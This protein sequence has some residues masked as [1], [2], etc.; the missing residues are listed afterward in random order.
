MG[1]ESLLMVPSAS[2][3]TSVEQAIVALKKGAHLFT[4]NKSK[5]KPKFCLFRLSMDE[6]YMI[7]YSGQNEKQL[8]LSSIANII[9]GQSSTKQVMLDKENRT[10]LSLI[11]ANGKC[12][13]QLICKDKVETESWFIG[14]RAVISRNYGN[15]SVKK[16][17]RGTQSCINS[18]ASFMRRKQNLVHSEECKSRSSQVHSLCGSP[19]SSYSARRNSNDPIQRDDLELSRS[20]FKELHISKDVYIWGG[21]KSNAL[22]LPK[23]VESTTMLDVHN[24]FLGSENAM[25]LTTRWGEAYFCWGEGKT[26]KT[27]RPKIIESLVGVHVDLISS[28]EHQTCAL[29]LSGELYT[30][31]NNKYYNGSEDSNSWLP[32]RLSGSLNGVSIFSVAC[33]AWHSAIVSHSGELFTYG[34]GTFGVL[35]HGD[36]RNYP[37]PKQV[38]SVK[39]LR[40]KAVAC[41]PWHTAAIIENKLFTWGDSDKGKLGHSCNDKRKVVLVPTYVKQLFGHDFVQVSCGNTITVVLTS[42]GRVYTMGSGLKPGDN[43]IVE[44]HGRLTEEFVVEISSGSYHIAVLT[45]KGNVYTWGK[46]ENGQ[47][48]LGDTKDR[49]SPSLVDALRGKKVEKITCGSS[50]TAVVCSDMSLSGD[51]NL[52]CRGCG[53]AFGFTR[54][55]RRCYNCGRL[56]CGACS[57]KRSACA[58]SLAPK[59]N[60]AF[61]VCNGCFDY[62]QSSVSSSS[63]AVF[64]KLAAYKEL[65]RWGQVSCPRN[66]TKN[67]EGSISISAPRLGHDH[68]SS[69]AAASNV[70]KIVLLE[71]IMKLKARVDSLEKLCRTREEKIIENR[72]E[73]EKAWSVAEEE[74]A[75]SKEAKK[76]IQALTLKFRAMSEKSYGRSRELENK[77]DFALSQTK[78]HPVLDVT[79]LPNKVE[80]N[81]IVFSNK[82]R[83]L[84]NRNLRSDVGRAN[85]V[86]MGSE[87]SELE[88]VEEHQPGIYISF[89]ALPDG[90]TCLKRVRFSRK[91]FNDREAKRWWEEN[92]Q[93]VCRNYR[94]DVYSTSDT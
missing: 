72:K 48:G 15:G 35:G 33:G 65:P 19:T 37:N 14:L 83:S 47:L 4:L 46:G 51:G 58:S 27:L 38:E 17:Q 93:T 36:V 60:K 89:T 20:T 16:L 3:H 53:G 49:N 12:S 40:V 88:W 50:S 71:E 56:F 52:A 32:R 76:L 1:E 45:S 62:L 30:W 63:S 74:A 87:S 80:D 59:E 2:S 69:T 31:G 18:P 57:S 78:I 11:D 86:K 42:K 85:P 77:P 9:H 34:D 90:K 23:L 84:C 82:F 24:I 10:C 54:K 79:C 64:S 41:G 22:L 92:Q 61:R 44:V 55:K 67:F 6:K 28:G 13:L 43:S 73:T 91:I 70:E 68:L 5:A 39:G 25:Q 94:V 66:F 26:V 8:K 75:K 7:W 21:T 81:N 29:T